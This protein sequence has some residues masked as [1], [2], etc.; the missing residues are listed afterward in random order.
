M[1]L[2][3]IKYIGRELIIFKREPYYREI[4]LI[5]DSEV[6]AEKAA[7]SFIHFLSCLDG[8]YT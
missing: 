3:E 8:R 6:A 2:L 7:I 1:D 4:V 5:F